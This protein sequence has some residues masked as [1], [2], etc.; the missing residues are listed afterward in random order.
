MRAGDV[1][2]GVELARSRRPAARQDRDLARGPARLTTALGLRGE[3]NGA[4]LCT[5]ASSPDSPILAPGDE[6][7][8]QVNS[9]PRVGLRH[10]A[11]APWRFW[12]DGAASVS[13]YRPHVKRRRS[14]RA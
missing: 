3:H 12:L 1:V 4:D 2:S 11:D 13:T 14:R 7:E 8:A 6:N 10:A 9:G 5:A